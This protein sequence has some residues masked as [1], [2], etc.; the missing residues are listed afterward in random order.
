MPFLYHTWQ[1]GA[2]ECNRKYIEQNARYADWCVENLGAKVALIA[3][4]HM[5]LPPT[6]EIYEGMEHK[7]E[8]KLISSDEYLV[9]DMIS[10]LSV[11]KV[12][13]TTRYHAHVLSS[14]A[15]VPSIAVS[16]DTRLEAVF[17]ELNMMEYYIEYVDHKHPV[18]PKVGDLYPSLVEMTRSLLKREK[19]I[20]TKI[21]KGHDEFVRRSELNKTLFTEWFRRT[22]G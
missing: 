3:M 11:L 12:L 17:K 21:L 2:R 6:K 10:I 1:K 16:S 7:S 18:P 22:Y 19:E 20:Q 14:H 13:V 8:A 9:D 4:E 15:G 5:D